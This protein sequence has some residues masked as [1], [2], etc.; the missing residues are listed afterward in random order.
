MGRAGRRCRL[1]G[2]GGGDE[3]TSSRRR[4]RCSP[5]AAAVAGVGAGLGQLYP[6]RA[7]NPDKG[8]GAAPEAGQRRRERRSPPGV[9]RTR[10]SPRFL[11]GHCRRRGPPL[12]RKSTPGSPPARRRRLPAASAVASVRA[13]GGGRRRG[14]AARALPVRP[15]AR[16]AGCPRCGGAV[17]GAMQ[18][19][20]QPYEFFSEE[21]SPKWRGLLVSALRKV[22]AGAGAA[23]GL[24]AGPVVP[25]ASNGEQLVPPTGLESGGRAVSRWLAMGAHKCLLHSEGRFSSFFA[26]SRK[27]GFVMII[28]LDFMLQSF[29]QATSAVDQF[30][31]LRLESGKR[32]SRWY[33]DSF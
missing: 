3:E 32:K 18:Q 19:A 12:R 1:G 29:R 28:K 25:W 9:A 6:C 26:W 14:E 20:P 5:P 31:V 21:N 33:L 16:P 8:G 2:Q 23:G 7:A 10:G 22:S 15:P 4:R 17:A 24:G 27:E 30:V 13:G 11:C